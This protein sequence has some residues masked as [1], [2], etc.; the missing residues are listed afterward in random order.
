MLERG[1]NRLTLEWPCPDDA[2]IAAHRATQINALECGK[3]VQPAL[4]YGEV[5]ELA[6]QSACTTSEIAGNDVYGEVLA[7]A[8]NGSFQRRES[9]EMDKASL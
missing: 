2:Q 8:R 6:V 3:A 9:I 7:D 1:V 4:G 5:Y